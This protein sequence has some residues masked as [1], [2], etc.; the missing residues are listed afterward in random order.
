MRF[1]IALFLV[2]C[3]AVPPAFAQTTNTPRCAPFE[4][5]AKYTG[6]PIDYSLSAPA[7]PFLLWSCYAKDPADLPWRTRHCIE[8]PWSAI[9][10]RR[11]GDRSETIRAAPDP[12]AAWSASY[13]RHVSPTTSARCVALLKALR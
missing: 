4:D 5:S 10:L 9:D 2:A 1:L 7:G 12:L 13:K 6:M 8:A 3:C 11:L